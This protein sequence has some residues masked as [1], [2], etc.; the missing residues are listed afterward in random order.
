M[1]NGRENKNLII[2]LDIGTSKIVTIVAEAKS[3]G[4]MEI[5]GVGM[6]ESSGMKKGM[7]VNIDA[8]VAAI[9]RAL[10]EIP[11]EFDAV[12]SLLGLCDVAGYEAQGAIRL[13]AAADPAERGRYPF[14]VKRDEVPWKLGFGPTLRALLDDRANGAEVSLIAARFHET[15][16]AATAVVAQELCAARNVTDVVLSGGVFQN[17]LF[18]Q[19]TRSALQA[20]GLNVHVNSLVPPNDGGIS[21]GQAA[22]AVARGAA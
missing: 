17:L 2:G 7:V 4:A 16:A 15:V 5:I 13:E 9:Q 21:L 6:Y 20:V 10:G 22:V 18:L 12:A 19:R 11:G 1:S 3:E 14:D 8:T